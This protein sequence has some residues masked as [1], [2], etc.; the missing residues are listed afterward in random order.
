M[1]GVL[2]M[3]IFILED[4]RNVLSLIDWLKSQYEVLHINNI[5]DAVYYLEYEEEL[6]H[7]DKFIFDAALP[8]ASVKHAD[9]RESDYTGVLNG[10]DLLVENYR[11]WGFDKA[12]NKVA[13]LSAYDR[14]LEKYKNFLKIK[15][16]T[17]II[18]KY[19]SDLATSIR[20]FINR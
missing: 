8:A 17:T 4:D 7:C 2:P 18:S 11:L 16:D 19:D 15:K 14:T 13:V 3:K 5:E 9:G 6:Q 12:M 10:V 20:S 1:K